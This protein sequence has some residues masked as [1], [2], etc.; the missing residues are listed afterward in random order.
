MRR[1][2]SRSESCTLVIDAHQEVGVRPLNVGVQGSTALVEARLHSFIIKVSTEETDGK[3]GRPSWRGHI[4]HV[5]GG[6]RG[7]LNDLDE[8]A[9]FIA[10]YLMLTAAEVGFGRKLRQWLGL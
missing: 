2:S 10:P 8:I 4:I 9:A 1:R 3:S 6:E 7:Y 5:P